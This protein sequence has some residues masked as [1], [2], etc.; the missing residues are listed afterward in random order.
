MS[1]EKLQKTLKHIKCVAV[2]DKLSEKTAL[3]ITYTT[4][5]YP[6]EY[7]PTTF[8]N[9]SANFMVDDQSIN[10]Q[11]WDTA[12]QEGYEKLRPLSYGDTD[13]FLVCFSLVHPETFENAINVWIPEIIEHCPNSPYILVGT[14]QKRRDEFSENEEEYRSK[15]FEPVSTENVIE[16]KSSTLAYDYIECECTTINKC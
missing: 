1:I 5:S 8:D 3:L 4:G 16:A 11:L 13:V 6:G 9:Y 14:N 10:L 12:C 7:V 15:G 2:G